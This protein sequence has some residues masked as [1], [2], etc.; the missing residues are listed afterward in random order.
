MFIHTD[1]LKGD[2]THMGDKNMGYTPTQEVEFQNAKHSIADE[3][4][5]I[6]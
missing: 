5:D 3:D 2:T 6:S 1:L 4:K